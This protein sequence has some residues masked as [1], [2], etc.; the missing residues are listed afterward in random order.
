[1]PA[2]KQS[3]ATISRA[4]LSFG[5]GRCRKVSHPN[6]ARPSWPRPAWPC[7]QGRSGRRR[8]PPPMLVVVMITPRE[9][10]LPLHIAGSQASLTHIM[11]LLSPTG[12]GA[13]LVLNRL[14]IYQNDAYGLPGPRPAALCIIFVS[15]KGYVVLFWDQ[16]EAS[17]WSAPM[18]NWPVSEM[19]ASSDIAGIQSIRKV[20]AGLGFQVWSWA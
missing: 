1:V 20:V 9:A 10:C 13:R 12:N 14:V 11:I 3:P 16:D 4:F 19:T 17:P 18:D 2:K 5:S 6:R 7:R 15:Q 8:G